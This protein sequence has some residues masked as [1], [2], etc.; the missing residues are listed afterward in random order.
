MKFIGDI[1]TEW[2][3]D[4]RK[5]RLLSPCAFIDSK[6]KYWFAPSG[7]IV[8]GASIPRILW[9]IVTPFI[10]KYRRAS[11]LHDHYCV[12][13]TASYNATHEMFYDGMICDGVNK[14]IAYMM[15][16]AVLWFGPK[17]RIK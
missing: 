15:Y 6:E 12:I 10:G 8:D 14:I 7:I 16:K 13:K 2:L 3:D 11:V 5:M 4:G 9:R 17:W 1:E